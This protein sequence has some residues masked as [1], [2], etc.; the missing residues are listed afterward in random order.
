[1][2]E[3]FTRHARAAV[4]D[5]QEVARDVGAGQIDSRHLTLSLLRVPGEPA[6]ALGRL[7]VDGPALA[8]QA[9]ARLADDDLDPEALGTIGID[10]AQVTRRTDEV[11]G[12]GALRR[13]GRERGRLRF[14][15]D[16]KK[17]LELA[18]REAVAL[19]DRSIE[20]RHL[21]LGILRADCP[22]RE[23]LEA[24]GVDLRR[25]RADLR[26]SRAKSA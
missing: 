6:E 13:A 10:L 25:L 18:L 3:R 22:G 1:M 12:I 26:E 15:R 14:R 17:A 16:A 20:T 21:M 11:F 2:F 19:G 5:A 7:G 9:T 8:E 4:I 23:L 24:S